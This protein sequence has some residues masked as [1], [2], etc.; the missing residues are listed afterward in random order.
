MESDTPLVE[1]LI[2]GPGLVPSGA[3]A[4]VPQQVLTTHCLLGCA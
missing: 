1:A 2:F 4:A 3:Q